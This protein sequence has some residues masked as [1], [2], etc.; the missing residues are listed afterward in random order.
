MLILC[1]IFDGGGQLKEAYYI[2]NILSAF[3]FVQLMFTQPLLTVSFINVTY[4]QH[5]ITHKT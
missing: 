5:T 1:D 3:S 2:L 4:T